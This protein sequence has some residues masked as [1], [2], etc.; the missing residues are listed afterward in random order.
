MSPDR[1]PLVSV[2]IIGLRG[3]GITVEAIVDTGFSDYLTLPKW[4]VTEMQLP[5][6]ETLYGGLADGSSAPMD[7]HAATVDWGGQRRNIPVHVSSCTPLLGIGLLYGH[8]LTLDVV[9]GGHIEIRP[10]T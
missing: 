6:I 9:D 1:E 3:D 8:R 5:Y 2:D 4:I 7:I 10:L